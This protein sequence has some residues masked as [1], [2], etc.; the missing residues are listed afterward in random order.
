MPYP[1]PRGAEGPR[2]HKGDRGAKGDGIKVDH[3]VASYGDL[4][5]NV[6]AGYSVMN[7][8]DGRL[9]VFDGSAYPAEGDGIQLRGEKGEQGDQGDKGDKGDKGTDGVDGVDGAGVE[10][11]GSVAT[12]ADLPKGLGAG[13]AGSGYIV[14][15]P[16]GRLYIWDGSAFPADGQGVAFRGPKGDKG[17]KGDKGEVG[18][19]GADGQVG[20][21]FRADP[22]FPGLFYLNDTLSAPADGLLALASERYRLAAKNA[23]RDRLRIVTLGDSTNDGF[24]A[25]QVGATDSWAGTWPQ[26]LASKLRGHL[27]VPAGGQGWMPPM[28]PTGPGS[29]GYRLGELGPNTATGY[30]ALNFQVGIPGSLWLQAGHESN[31]FTVKYPLRAGTTSVGIVTTQYGGRVEVECANAAASTT[32]EGTGDRIYT[33]VDNPGSSVLVRGAEGVGFALLGI[34][35][36]VGDEERGVTQFNLSQAAIRGDEIAGWLEDPD[37]SLKPLIVGADP[38][39]VLV[40]VGGNDFGA[41]RSKADI[42]Q[43]MTRINA[44]M[45]EAA[46]RADVVFIVRPAVDDGWDDFADHMVAAAVRIG[47]HVLDVRKSI[48]ADAPGLFLDDRTH[49]TVAGEQAMAEAVLEFMKVGA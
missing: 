21:K 41:G 36:Y 47:A 26:L 10:I 9:Y 48:A 15:I 29:Y 7:N 17:D 2:G 44:Q 5:L 20:A 11:A 34:V 46:P 1:G 4:P 23:G 30:D 37:M 33:R 3:A 18:Q 6:A 16:D 43:T 39:V 19:Q 32:I 49:W 45:L 31:A 12:Y 25:G 24:S 28:P 40:T 38:N 14:R 35:E 42:E 8:A 22:N 27:G 13:Q